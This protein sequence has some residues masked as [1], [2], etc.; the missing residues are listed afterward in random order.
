MLR[1]T[2]VSQDWSTSA[3]GLDLHLDLAAGLGCGRRAGLESALRDAIRT[4]RLAPCSALPSTR[5]LARH[6]GVS[7]GTVTA[8]YDQLVAEGYLAARHGSGTTV[9]E[10]PGP[11]PGPVTSAERDAAPRHDLRPGRPDPTTFPAAAWLRATKKVLA[12]AP[13]EIHARGDPAGRAELRAALAGYLGRSRGVLGRPD[14]IV[15]M[16][17][18]SQALGL[19]ARVLAGSGTRAIAMED[20]GHP[21]HR[22][23]VRRAGL[24][25]LALPVDDRGART[26]LLAGPEFTAAGAAVLTPAHQYPAGA[27]LHPD[28]RRAAA[29]WALATGGLVIEDDYDGEFR[30]DRQPVGAVQGTAPDGV[31]Y[32]G[33]AS[34]ALAPALRLGW[35][36]LPPRLVEAVTDAKHHADTQTAALSQLVL[37]ELITTHAYDRHVRA[38]RL[39]YRRRRDQL[40]ER[41]ASAVPRVRVSGV[42]AGLHALVLLPGPGGP[43]LDEVLGRAAGL[44][45]ALQPLDDHWHA[46][47]GHPRGLIIGYSTPAGS[48]WP[49]ALDALCAALHPAA[50]SRSV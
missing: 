11:P 34:K 29:A 39:R 44:G 49:A 45:L 15:I 14:Q 36:V 33:T 47:G 1:S 40:V 16:S 24:K 6:L 25:I 31:A 20:P 13:A 42:A 43:E 22:E 41:L 37:A 28:R 18:Y 2:L 46:R 30:Y 10:V 48:A 38:A 8:A 4:G 12:T 35:I 32:V 3:R 27:T 19:L 7:R 21:F 50:A 17:G 9:A 23:I 26:D 5:A